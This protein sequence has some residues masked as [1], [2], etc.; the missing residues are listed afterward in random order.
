MTP[1]FIFWG[2]PDIAVDSLEA[3]KTSS[4]LPRLII[5][6][7]DSPKGRNG[8]TSPSLVKAW[9]I[10]NNIPVLTPEKLRTEEF[11]AELSPEKYGVEAW[12]VFVVVAYGKIIPQNIL[13]I[14]KHGTIN[15]HPSLLP[16]HRGPAPIKSQILNEASSEGVGVSVMLLDADMDHGPVLAQKNVANK[17]P[18]W[19]IGEKELQHL[20][21]LH[22]AELLANTLPKWVEGSIEA[23]E[24]DHTQAT[25][26]TKVTKEDALINLSDDPQTNY[27]KILAYE[28]W[29]RPYFFTE[30]GGKVTRAIITSA[31]YKNDTLTIERVIPEG[32][33]E[34][35]YDVFLRSLS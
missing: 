22:G 24:Q 9:A 8:T 7:P 25:Y 26:C 10:E 32:K 13:D 16:R 33:K 12:D 2:T 35:P 4:L 14:P 15:M 20:L 34:M 6:A 23:K 27:R 18:V 30:N 31:S 3:L 19:P 11:L 21:S 17:L 28:L 5:T 1:A 29:P